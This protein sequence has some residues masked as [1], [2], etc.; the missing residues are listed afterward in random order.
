MRKKTK[1]VVCMTIAVV[2]IFAMLLPLAVS[3]SM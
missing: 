2:L 1:R 3:L